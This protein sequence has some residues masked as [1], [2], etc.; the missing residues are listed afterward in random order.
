LS[1][2]RYRRYASDGSTL[3]FGVVEHLDV[4]EHITPRASP[5]QIYPPLDPLTLDQQIEASRVSVLTRALP[6]KGE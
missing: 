2:E 4:I 6:M 5:R 3:A 1:F